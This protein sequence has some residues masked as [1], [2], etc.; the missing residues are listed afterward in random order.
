[1][2]PKLLRASVTEAIGERD[3]ASATAPSVDTV[4]GFIARAEKSKMVETRTKEQTL[5][6]IRESAGVMS[7]ETRPA[8]AA[9][10]AWIHRSYIAK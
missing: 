6:G 9:A 4:N 5:I 8:A 3:A 10:D 2:W 7:L 1:M